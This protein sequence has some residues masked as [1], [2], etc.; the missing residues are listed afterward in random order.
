M[1]H[2]EQ[3]SS[4]IWAEGIHH[5]SYSSSEQQWSVGLQWSYS[6]ELV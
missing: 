5:G 2:E 3:I 6:N 4:L 1:T